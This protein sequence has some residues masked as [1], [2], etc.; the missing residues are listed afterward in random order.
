MAADNGRWSIIS[1]YVIN[2]THWVHVSIFI[3]R[4]DVGHVLLL[5]TFGSCSSCKIFEITA[6]GDISATNN[7]R[8]CS[9]DNKISAA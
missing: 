3:L 6:L 7:A 8:S 2:A 4:N 9:Y 1:N 5:A